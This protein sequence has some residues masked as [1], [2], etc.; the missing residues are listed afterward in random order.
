MLGHNFFFSLTRKYISIFGTLFNDINIS[1][2][3]SNNETIGFISVPITYGPKEKMVMRSLSDP[4]LGRPFAI[5]LPAMSFE[6]KKIQYDG[7]RKLNTIGKV[8]RP[9]ST[10]N[11][12]LVT[13]YN[14]VPYNIE[15]ELN[16]YVK[17]AVDGTKII[18]QI[19]PFFTPDWTPT[20]ELIPEL[21][22]KMD[23]PIVL[24]D[25]SIEDTYD[26]QYKDRRMLIWTLRFDMK[27]YYYGPISKSGVIKFANISFHT[28]MDMSSKWAE[29]VTVQPGLTANGEPTQDITKTIPYQDINEDDPYDY[30]TIFTS[31]ED[32]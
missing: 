14:P 26:E 9:T 12:A 29:K 25:I 30:I 23:I 20:V 13:Q 2:E 19:L 5:S 27:A 6:F 16:V 1:R 24:K 15:W 31:I 8:V 7:D 21:G 32:N 17:N 11:N 22:I 10:N 3:N 18:E 4:N 28:S